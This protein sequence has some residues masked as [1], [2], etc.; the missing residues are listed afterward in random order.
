M[1]T[2][3]IGTR[4]RRA[5]AG[6]SLM[7]MMAVVAII[8]ILAALA[9]V[10]YM[11]WLQSAK[12]ADAKDLMQALSSAE[13]QYYQDT[14]GYLSCSASYADLYPMPVAGVDGRSKH[15]F[16]NPG[17]G[18]FA[19]FRLLHADSETATYL[20]FAV[21]AGQ[22]G[23]A[24]SQPPTQQQ[25]SEAPEPGKPWFVVYG[26]TDKDGDGQLGRMYTTSMKPG[27]VHME[28]PDE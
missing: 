22:A 7:E 21:R 23:S 11:K 19:C 25:I 18:S 17:H 8:G 28:N 2:M 6:Y 20:S 14:E 16:H 15:H 24:I 4:A 9:V 1:R 10:G 27:E 3:R 5:R 12:I 26:E 13:H